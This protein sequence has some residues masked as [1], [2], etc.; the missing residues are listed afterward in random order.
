MRLFFAIDFTEAV[1]N[2]LASAIRAIPVKNPP[3]RWISSDN[4]HVTLKFLGET[5]EDQVDSLVEC[6]N[7]VAGVFAPFE[8]TLGGLGGFPDLKNPRVLFYRIDNGVEPLAALATR[9]ADALDARFG[10]EPDR[11]P[12]KAHA[13]VARIKTR[14]PEGIVK[15][16]TAVPGLEGVHQQVDRMVLV[17]SRLSSQGARYQ[18][19]KAFALSKS[20]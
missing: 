17:Q 12:F 20:K 14:I 13:T 10:I 9:L 5:G 8:I 15:K 11:R 18:C 3:W 16:L 1:K 4:I 7:G 19:L 2:A 6:A